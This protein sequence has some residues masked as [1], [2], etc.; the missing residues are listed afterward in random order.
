MGCS[1][2][3]PQQRGKEGEKAKD[4]SFSFSGPGRVSAATAE[5]LREGTT[6]DQER[7]SAILQLSLSLSLL[8]A[9]R[10]RTE[11]ELCEAAVAQRQAVTIA[12]HVSIWRVRS[13][14]GGKPGEKGGGPAAGGESSPP[15][16]D[17]L[18]SPASTGHLVCLASDAPGMVG[19][20]LSMRSG[21][22]VQ[23]GPAPC[24]ALANARS[25]D[26]PPR[27][28]DLASDKDARAEIEARHGTGVRA[29]V[30]V[31]VVAHAT[32]PSGDSAVTPLGVIELVLLDKVGAVAALR[33]VR[34][35][36]PRS[37]GEGADKPEKRGSSPLQRGS[38]GSFDDKHIGREGSDPRA[39]EQ[40][41]S[42]NSSEPHAASEN[43]SHSFKPPFSALMP[44]PG[45]AAPG[46][47]AAGLTAGAPSF[48]FGGG[49]APGGGA[50]G[51]FALGSPPMER[52]G[53]SERKFRKARRPGSAR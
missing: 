41:A 39:S 7:M 12:D 36:S 11:S 26:A 32:S 18:A 3:R 27:V 23:H 33:D 31:P 25:V 37:S 17:A 51:G 22:N 46:G 30:Y 19:R 48:L 13:G 9:E 10:G 21:P 47:A 28:V 29:A 16:D 45:G 38:S 15:R 42:S 5:L 14:H 1:S 53:G 49:G 20:A 44:S 2:S 40:R 4:D 43:E 6:R 24:V 35:S 50:P 34:A 8:A 52:Q